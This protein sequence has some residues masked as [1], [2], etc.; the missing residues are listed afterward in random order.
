[1]RPLLGHP[2]QRL[3]QS[4]REPASELRRRAWREGS[5]GRE[6]SVRVTKRPGALGTYGDLLTGWTALESAGPARLSC[7]VSRRTDVGPPDLALV[8]RTDLLH[9]AT[10]DAG[11]SANRVE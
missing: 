2:V 7:P 1:V 11:R 8:S 3:P 4:G 10:R 5:S 9:R 6:H